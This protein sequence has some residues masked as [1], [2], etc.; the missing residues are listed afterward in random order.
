MNGPDA[1]AVLAG[2]A[3]EFSVVF[4]SLEPIRAQFADLAGAAGPV[5]RAGLTAL[6]PEISG[7]LDRH[8]RLV[9]GAGVIVV[10]DLL[11]DTRYWLEWWWSPC[12]A[13]PG[14]LRVNL[15][16]RS[17]DFFD[18]TVA[19]WFA[20][21]RDTVRPHVSGP[22]VDYACT[23]E[24]AITIALP[25]TAGGSFAGVAA[26]DVL[27]SSLE[28]RV[29]P[30]LRGLSPSCVLTTGQGRVVASASPDYA[31]GLRASALPPGGVPAQRS[32]ARCEPEWQ[33]VTLPPPP[34][35]AREF[36]LDWQLLDVS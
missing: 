2:V 30:R 26:A 22:S 10:P 11:A 3:A 20:V 14:R 23:S 31:P 4:A 17:P 9:A 19:D 32:H 27:V 1:R 34:P 36:V 12:G 5:T 24:Y 6:Q 29:L 35:G 21:P 15:D 16:P 7:L 8:S 28:E 25:V 13:E 33:R 18:Y